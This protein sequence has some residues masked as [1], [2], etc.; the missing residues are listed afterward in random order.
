MEVWKDFSEL[1]PDVSRMTQCRDSP[2][3]T[4]YRYVFRGHYSGL[5]LDLNMH[6]IQDLEL[7]D[8]KLQLVSGQSDYTQTFWLF[9]LHSLS[10][11]HIIINQ[12][13]LC[14]SGNLAFSAS[15][16]ISQHK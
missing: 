15:D 14:F 10:S 13:L 4:L 16:L 7:L 6:N 3:T 2:L 8:H 5:T 9:P 1:N 11:V 12:S